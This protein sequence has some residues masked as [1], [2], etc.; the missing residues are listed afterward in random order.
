[1]IEKVALALVITTHR[2]HMYFQNHQII[3][4]T[5]YPIMKI[6]AKPDLV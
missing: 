5:Y 6:L 1:M 3:V 4:R 2:I